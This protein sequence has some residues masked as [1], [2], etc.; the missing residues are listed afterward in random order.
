MKALFLFISIFYCYL[1]QAQ[2]LSYCELTI[3]PGSNEIF[4]RGIILS[5]CQKNPDCELWSLELKE[6]VSSTLTDYL[7]LPKLQMVYN[8]EEKSTHKKNCE[9]SQHL[10]SLLYNYNLID[11]LEELCYNSEQDSGCF[12]FEP[13]NFV[14]SIIFGEGSKFDAAGI[15][16]LT[17]EE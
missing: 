16:E 3:S 4:H 6:H 8:L 12:S 2:K 11:E 9:K 13:L 5:S 7:L 17:I 10:D 14:H 15:M 1:G